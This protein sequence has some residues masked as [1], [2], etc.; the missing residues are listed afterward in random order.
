MEFDYLEFKEE[1]D[2]QL[3][4]IED[5]FSCKTSAEK[6]PFKPHRIN[7]FMLLLITEGKMT[8][9]VDF[10]AYGMVKGDCLFISKEQIHQFDSSPHYKGYGFLFTEK[11]MLNHFSLSAFNKINFLYNYHIKQ[12]LFRDFKDQ[13]IFLRALKREFS[14]E[15]GEI[16]VDLVACILSVF[17]MKAQFHIGQELKEN[18]GD[19]VKF[20]RFQKLVASKHYEI[21]TTKHYAFLL[22]VTQKQLNKLCRA[23]TEMTA[24]EYINRYLIME[25]KRRLATTDFPVNQ[26]AFDCGFSESTNFLKFFKKHA[27]TTPA[28]FRKTRG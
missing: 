10:E 22:N 25:A 24:K 13:K 16:K 8:H 20:I 2:F 21:R 18:D 15:L 1:F 14:L 28:Q 9:E 19:Y 17:L 26:I 27:R 11:F 7:F 6:N 5:V 12:P 3:F 4:Q 23:F